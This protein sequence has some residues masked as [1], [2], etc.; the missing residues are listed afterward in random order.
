MGL[1]AGFLYSSSRWE[2]RWLCLLTKD[3]ELRRRLMCISADF[4][5]VPVPLWGNAPKVLK[6]V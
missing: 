5:L 1:D 4:K 3:C 2:I 6:V